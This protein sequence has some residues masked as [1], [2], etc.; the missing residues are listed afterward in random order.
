MYYCHVP[1]PVGD[2]LLAADDEGLRFLS[3]PTG[4][5]PRRPHV[6]WQRDPSRLKQAIEQLDAYFA[7]ELIRFDLTLAPQG[8]PFQLTVWRT[9]L[10]IPYGQTK[11][12]GEIAREVGDPGASRPVGAANG[13]NPIAIIIPCHRV[14]GST[15]KLTGFGGGVE[16]KVKL[17]ALERRHRPEAGGQL[18]LELGL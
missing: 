9:L 13:A 5:N 15:G 6:T 7:G 10:N 18:E 14:I 11:S 1:S 3:F 16:T 2:L 4:K 8:N 12:Y 17:L